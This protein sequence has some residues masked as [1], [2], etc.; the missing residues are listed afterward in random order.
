MEPSQKNGLKS[1]S[2]LMI[3]HIQSISKTRLLE[4][5]GKLKAAELK[6]ALA[7]LNDITTLKKNHPKDLTGF[8]LLF[9]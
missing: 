4:K 8:R 9:Q 5:I 2:E 3:F 6:Q 1:V 7:T